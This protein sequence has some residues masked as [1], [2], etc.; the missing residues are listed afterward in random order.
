[1]ED[2]NSSTL[3]SKYAE[4]SYVVNSES[5]NVSIDS[6]HGPNFHGQL[7]VELGPNLFWDTTRWHLGLE[8]VLI[9]SPC[10]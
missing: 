6:I 7:Q 9:S 1:M 10:W 8:P 3:F 2:V 4:D 5:H